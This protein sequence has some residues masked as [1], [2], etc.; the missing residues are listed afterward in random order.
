MRPNQKS[1]GES[2]FLPRHLHLRVSNVWR[3]NYI[4]G[5]PPNISP[6]Q[7]ITW[8]REWDSNPRYLAVNTLSKR[9]PSAT[10]P[11]LPMLA[12]SNFQN[13]PHARKPHFASENRGRGRMIS[14]PR[15]LSYRVFQCSGGSGRGGPGR[16]GSASRASGSGAQT[17]DPAHAQLQLQRHQRGDCEQL[18]VD[19]VLPLPL[20]AICTAGQQGNNATIGPQF[21]APPSLRWSDNPSC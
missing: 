5:R 6:L 12:R 13:L 8:R 15:S 7:S 1:L 11:S 21:F 19:C 4:S 3:N 14:T 16:R 9:A 20:S 10:R 17:R 18:P 2:S